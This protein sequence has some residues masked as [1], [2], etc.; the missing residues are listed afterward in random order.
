VKIGIDIYGGDFAPEATVLGSIQAFAEL[1]EG[2][3][4]VLIGNKNDIETIC[5]R[6]G[7]DPKKFEIIHTDEYI[8]MSDHPAKAFQTK[9]KSSIGIGFKLLHDKK[10]DGFAS[11][12]NT[13][14]MMVGAMYTIKAIHGVMRPVIS[15]VIPNGTAYP[16]TLL[17]VGINPDAKPE[18]LY[19]YAIL[20]SIY[21]Q[22]IYKIEKPKVA[23][24]NIGSEDEKGN[25]AAKAAFQLLKESKDINFVGNIEGNQLFR[26]D[27][28]DVIVCDG[29]VGNV[30]LKEAE[31][32]YTLTKKRKIEDPFFE[33]F[34]FENYGGTPILGVN[35]TAVIGHG[36]SNAKA[37]KNML[38]QTRDMAKAELTQKIKKAFC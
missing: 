7:F 22:C 34:N 10:L 17:D 27:I 33:S 19:Q 18:V 1:N 30:V 24:L 23:L 8:S 12:G 13:G 6:E 36:V 2:E 32:F 14:A 4:L 37:I 3:S 31:A 25:L 9:T 11:A 35:S 38:L 21:V 20:G 16:S 29:F 26:P 5:L 28:A 15:S